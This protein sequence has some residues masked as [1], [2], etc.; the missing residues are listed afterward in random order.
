MS[1]IVK[2]LTYMNNHPYNPYSL[3]HHYQEDG[4]ILREWTLKPNK[5]DFRLNKTLFR[6]DGSEHIEDL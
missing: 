5:R 3:T 4:S 2:S 1:I 6:T